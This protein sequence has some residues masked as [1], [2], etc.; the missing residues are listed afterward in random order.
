[1]TDSLNHTSSLQLH[2]RNSISGARSSGHTTSRASLTSTISLEKATP[3]SGSTSSDDADENDADENDE[4]ADDG[5]EES[6]PPLGPAERRR[7]ERR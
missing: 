4:D 7:E 5:F 2:E 1:M 6:R 3:R